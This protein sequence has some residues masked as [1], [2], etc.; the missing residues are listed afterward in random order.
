[1]YVD[2]GV[3][4]IWQGSFKTFFLG[5]R[6]VPIKTGSVG[7]S[8]TWMCSHLQ[9]NLVLNILS[10]LSSGEKKLFIYPNNLCL[11]GQLFPFSC[12]ALRLQNV[13]NS[14]LHIRYFSAGSYL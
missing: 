4:R 1:M 2:L 12:S 7:S 13:K 6:A 3:G 8:E 5:G 11:T 10:L 14:T 9:H